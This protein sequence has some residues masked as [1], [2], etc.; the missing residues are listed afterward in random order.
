MSNPGAAS[1]TTVNLSALYGSPI[2]AAQLARPPVD[3]LANTA[4]VYQGAD[5]NLYRSDGASL[6]RYAQSTSLGPYPS[7]KGNVDKWVTARARGS[8]NPARFMA[9]GDSNLAGVGQGT[10][11][12]NLTGAALVNMARLTANLM[13][14]RSENV[15]GDQNVGGG[16]PAVALNVYNP[17]TALG[18]GWSQAGATF[19]GEFIVGAAGAAGRF[20]YT[21]ATSI[22][23][24]NLYYAISA[25]GNTAVTVYVDGVLVDT[26][27]AVGANGFGQKSYTVTPGIH[28]LEVGAGA[29]GSANIIG[30]ETFDNS[31]T[32]TFINGAAGSATMAIINTV[33]APFSY[34]NVSVSLVPDLVWLYATIN[35]SGTGTTEANYYTAVETFVARYPSANGILTAGYPSSTNSA[36][37]SGVLDTYATTLQKIA[38]DYGW[39]FFDFR[40]VFGGSNVKTQALG[41][42]YDVSHPN[43]AGAVAASAAFRNFLVSL[44]VT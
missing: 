42:Y 13:G 8:A 18:T 7:I 36:A 30:F 40:Q 16:A 26:F 43:A 12:L 21:P 29:T 38:T 5:G 11:P 37:T 35:D 15:L 31:A 14:W 2:T 41:Y 17:Q 1:S 44:G 20:G 19:G 3:I 39:S 33:T 34:A 22:R 6:I 24:F 4:V 32:P 28:L 10:G 27:S 9:M 23:A 25:S